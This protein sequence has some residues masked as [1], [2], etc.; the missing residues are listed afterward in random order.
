MENGNKTDWLY[1]ELRR[2]IALMRDGEAF[3]TVRE[4]I[5]EYDLSQATVTAAVKRLK[6]KG[7]IE[8]FVGRGSF[9]R[10]ESKAKPHLLLLQQN[11]ESWNITH[12]R[13]ELEQAAVR[14]GFELETVRFDYHSDICERLND[15]TADLI[16]LDSL[17][18]DQLTSRQVTALTQ[19]AVPVILCSYAVQIEGIRYVCGDNGSGGA[20]AARYLAQHGHSKIGLLY[21]EPHVLTSEAVANSFDF[22]AATCGCEVTLLDC[23]MQPGDRPELPIREFAKRYA[24]GE[25]DFSAMFAI[26][27]NGALL[28]IREF[29]AAGIA[30]PD[31]LSILGYGNVAMPG[32]ER[33]TTVNTPRD[34]I[35]EEVM[36]MAGNLLNHRRNFKTQVNVLPVMVERRSVRT[37]PVFQVV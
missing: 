13:Y 35:A 34:R 6:E 26:S 2:R 32:N 17:T 4:L 28:A 15:Y 12:V 5:A 9:V 21:C 22:V 29:E 3:P 14:H 37:L 16:I 11:W 33:L 36:A 23:G 30:V 1:R 18:N 25:Y 31:T 24:A 10:K 8:A 19:S 7:L 27:D 20:L